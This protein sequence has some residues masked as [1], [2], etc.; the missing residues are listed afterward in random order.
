MTEPN[1]KI[2]I[3]DELRK[4]GQIAERE[5]IVAWLRCLWDT[6]PKYRDLV[7]SLA[8]RIEGGEHRK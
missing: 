2:P 7:W 1:A 6:E 8:K 3:E 4:E 5:V